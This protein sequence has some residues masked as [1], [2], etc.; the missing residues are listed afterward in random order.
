MR[1]YKVLD[2]ELQKMLSDNE[3]S[4][5]KSQYEQSLESY[6]K[7]SENAMIIGV[8]SSMALFAPGLLWT[9]YSTRKASESER[10]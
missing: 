8:L 4:T 3:I 1:E 6:K 10:D 7:R 5:T 2:S 9:G